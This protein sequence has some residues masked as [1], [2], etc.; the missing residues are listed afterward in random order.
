MFYVIVQKKDNITL[1]V[2]TQVFRSFDDA[3]NE[4]IYLQPDY[5]NLLEVKQII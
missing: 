1:L 4:R 5:N 2:G 3:D